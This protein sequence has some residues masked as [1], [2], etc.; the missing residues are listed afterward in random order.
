MTRLDFD[1]RAEV[2]V[3]RVDVPCAPT[4]QTQTNQSIDVV[5]LCRPHHRPETLGV[6][7]VPCSKRDISQARPCVLVVVTPRYSGLEPE[8]RLRHVVVGV[9]SPARFGIG[10]GRI[11]AGVLP[12][13]WF[14]ENCDG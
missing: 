9:G 10:T 12:L 14:G 11:R 4:S 3:H 1:D 13:D 5:G 7:Y 8:P 6:L 2:V